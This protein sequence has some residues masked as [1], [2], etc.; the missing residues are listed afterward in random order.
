MH[1]LLL[2]ARHYPPAISGG[3]RRPFFLARGLRNLGLEVRVCAPSLP[4]GDSGWAV[5]H[6]QR[7]PQT[8]SLPSTPSIRGVGRDLLLWPDPDIRWALR[9]ARAVRESMLTESWRPDWILSTSPPESVHAAARQLAAAMGARWAADFRDHWLVAPHRHAR[10]RLHRILGERW[11]ARRLL[12]AADLILTVDDH[13]AEEIRDLGGVN[14]HT[15][16]HFAHDLDPE[17]VTLDSQL[18][19]I[20]HAGSIALSDPE[21]E[22]GALL[23]AFT[24]SARTRPELRLHF[25]GRLTDRESAAIASCPASAAIHEHG[26]VAYEQA[27]GWIQAADL[28]AFVASPKMHVP[29]SKIVEYS[30]VNVPILAVGEGPWRSDSRVPGQAPE[31]V[32]A[33]IQKRQPR[34]YEWKAPSVTETS[35]KLLDLFG[36]AH[37]EKPV[38]PG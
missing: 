29:P 38:Q 28:L 9:A 33:S 10:R 30:L 27:L 3:A 19:H 17:P 32:L 2:F 4:E 12:P 13:I 21:A 34:N 25:V 22:I 23:D 7:D 26:P 1:R 8:Q 35:R 15:L 36:G 18:I 20:V 31:I 5:P 24:A 14:V 6:P 16:P 11:H 37:L